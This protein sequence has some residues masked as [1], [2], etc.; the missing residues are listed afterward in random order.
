MPAAD[1]P[2]FVASNRREWTALVRPPAGYRVDAVLGTTFSLDFVALTA[3]L[4]GLLDQDTDERSWRDDGRLLQALTRLGERVRVLVNRARIPEPRLPGRLL[5]LYDR[6]LAEIHLPDASFHPKVWVMKYVPRGGASDDRP[7]YRA[8]FTSRNATEHSAWE[9][10]AVL[11]GQH[12][13][14]AGKAESLGR[15]LS[16]FFRRALHEDPAPP[17]FCARL[18]AELP[19]VAFRLTGEP[20]LRQ[21]SLRWQWPGGGNLADDLPER[22]SRALVVSPFVN[23]RF[24]ELLIARFEEVSVVARQAALDEFWGEDLTKALGERV[25]VIESGEGR[26]EDADDEE[27]TGDLDAASEEGAA[28]ADDDRPLYLDLH[29]KLL[30]CETRGRGVAGKTEAWLGSAN[31]TMRGWGLP[32]AAVNAEAMLR[33]SPGV[34][35]DAFIAQ[36]VGDPKKGRG[37]EEAPAL[38]KAARPNRGA[39]PFGILVREVA[40][41]GQ[42]P[43]HGYPA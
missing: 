1:S 31:A 14:D 42:P 9:L 29:A 8:L 26:E 13:K 20:T 4:L 43:P 3:L 21:A 6:I 2:P 30:L 10:A 12:D 16:A 15:D 17:R 39:A 27:P 33:F 22:G 23:R 34:G 25:W 37:R 19:K 24:L 32:G 36:F 7:I 35:V 5:T 18:V 40:R 41:R 38:A 28:A 11:E